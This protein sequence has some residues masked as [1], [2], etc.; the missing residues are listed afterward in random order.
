MSTVHCRLCNL[1]AK[2]STVDLFTHSGYF[3]PG[4]CRSPI[5]S[6]LYHRLLLRAPR[7]T[8]TS[9]TAVCPL[10]LLL[11]LLLLLLILLSARLHGTNS[12]DLH[13]STPR[14]WAVKTQYSWI[15]QNCD[16]ASVSPSSSVLPLGHLCS[17]V[18]RTGRDYTDW[19]F[20][21]CPGI[22]LSS[23]WYNS[24]LPEIVNCPHFSNSALDLSCGTFSP[25][26]WIPL[27]FLNGTVYILTVDDVY[28]YLVQHSETAACISLLL[29]WNSSPILM[30]QSL[31]CLSP[32]LSSFLSFRPVALSSA[33][34]P[35]VLS[36]PPVI[37]LGTS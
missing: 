8:W 27:F 35:R 23:S 6:E 28:S 34:C 22:V 18:P 7:S 2:L 14:S 31:S 17:S 4:D 36:E 15:F 24:T 13:R 11:L 5:H 33:V 21:P 12:S 26:A 1:R 10:G 30:V 32:E 29:P 9:C 19:I 25:P 20:S 3:V 37:P 16:P